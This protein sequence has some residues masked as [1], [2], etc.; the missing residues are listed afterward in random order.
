MDTPSCGLL[1]QQNVVAS[2]WNKSCHLMGFY[3]ILCIENGR[4]RMGNL[5]FDFL[6]LLFL[7]VDGNMVVHKYVE[8][9]DYT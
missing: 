1:L 8:I 5:W 4:M 7:C 9:S 6:C 3:I 2:G